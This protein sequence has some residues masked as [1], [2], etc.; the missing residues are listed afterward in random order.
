MST[1]G[2]TPWFL[3]VWITSAIAYD[4]WVC[5]AMTP[6]QTIS[7]FLL[8]LSLRWP[9]LPLAICFGIGVLAGHLFWPQ[10]PK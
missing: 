5:L 7:A 10:Q 6:E 4:L 9:L 8:R 3:L 2:P 1:N